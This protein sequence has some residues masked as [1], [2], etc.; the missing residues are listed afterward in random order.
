MHQKFKAY[1]YDEQNNVFVRPGEMGIGYV[2][3][4]ES[5]LFTILD[6]IADKSTFSDEFLPYM[7][8]WPTEY[9]L[10][11]K[12]HLI[13]RPFDIKPGD[14]VLELGCGCGAITRYLAECGADVVSVE[15]EYARASVASKRCSGL[16]NV[17]VI[18]DNL[19]DLDI[20]G[21]FDWILMIGVFEYSQK[22]GRSADK[23]QDYLK[24]VKKYLTD[25]GSLIT[26]IENK[27]GIKYLNG[28]SE[29]HNSTIHYGTQD[30]YTNLDVTT[31]GRLELIDILNNG[32]FT[33]NKFYG[34]FP[35]Y[36]IPKI[37][38]SSEINEVLEF[39][40]E[41]VLH[42][43]KSLD[44]SGNN[45]RYYDESLAL[46]SFRKNGMLLDFSNSFLICSKLGSFEN[47]PSKKILAYY[48]ATNRKAEHCT[49]TEFVVDQGKINITKQPLQIKKSKNPHPKIS[50]PDGSI[51]NLTHS[52]GKESTYQQGRLLSFEFTK[53]VWRKDFKLIQDLVLTW[54]THL[55]SNFNFY[56]RTTSERIN[57][58][59]LEN[60]NLSDVLIDGNA[61]DCGPHNLILGETTIAFD[62]EW[63]VDSPIPLSWVLERCCTHIYRRSYGG[64]FLFE[65]NDLTLYSAATMGLKLSTD[66][67]ILSRQLEEQLAA[68]IAYNEPTDAA[69]L[70]MKNPQ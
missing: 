40:A 31:W 59:N 6:N 50:N 8:D 1:S 19:L 67:I 3:G 51:Y 34:V 18:V 33:E 21:K 26:A 4:G 44:Y 65:S 45:E 15:G 10:S 11:R 69:V 29:D 25:D 47:V 32:G 35:D 42:Y 37:I 23:Q 38:F 20:E 53:A 57:I 54:T 48:F 43:S 58:A 52:H 16:D 41:E 64:K 36:K 56:D 68:Q 70:S 60:R 62:L 12:R 9:H 7:E 2:D 30:L 55:K 66:D 63:S 5:K 39:R 28:A 27:L 13:L 24:V 14:R 22:F 17:N 46:A 49:K 61:L